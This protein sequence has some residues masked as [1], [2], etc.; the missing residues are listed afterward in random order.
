MNM[1]ADCPSL[2]SYISYSQLT[3]RASHASTLV[4]ENSS[5][6]NALDS[7]Q[8]GSSVQH[9]HRGGASMDSDA[10]LSHE[11]EDESD[12]GQGKEVL[13]PSASGESSRV[14]VA[15]NMCNGV[16]GECARAAGTHAAIG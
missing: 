10:R 12:G 4:V 15:F 2:V 14:V 1:R 8:H 6:V 13:S 9:I 16:L 5:S 11:D 7:V 3:S